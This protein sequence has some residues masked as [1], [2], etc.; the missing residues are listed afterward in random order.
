MSSDHII[1][2]KLYHMD[3]EYPADLWSRISEQLPPEKKGNRPVFLLLLIGVLLLAMYGVSS[4]NLSGSSTD[5][6]SSTLSEV[7]PDQNISPKEDG[8][9]LLP[10]PI[11]KKENTDMDTEVVYSDE[12]SNGSFAE[13]KKDPASVKFR[14]TPIVN[15]SSVRNTT[16]NATPSSSAT[17]TIPTE[18]HFVT[19][20]I[21]FESTSTSTPIVKRQS[22]NVRKISK[23]NALLDTDRAYFFETLED[24][25]CPS[26]YED[27]LGLYADIY[28]NHEYGLRSLS[29]KS[30]EFTDY[31]DDRNRTESALYSFSAGARLSFIMPSGLG[32]KTGFNY[33]QINE[34][35]SFIDPDATMIR[36][37]ITI[38][39]ILVDGMQTV[40]SDTSRVE[41][42]GTNEIT[43]FNRLK[44]FDIPLLASYSI[45]LNGRWYAEV[46][47]GALF[48]VTFSKKGRILDSSGDPMWFGNGP[49]QERVD[50]YS[51]TAG[52]SLYLGAGFHYV[53]N[54]TFDIILEPNMTY[55][56]KTLTLDSYSLDQRY[57]RIGLITGLRYKF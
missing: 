26:F 32:L 27:K 7:I 28:W 50:V 21:N 35:F 52:V 1:R 46:N 16:Y 10:I 19:D 55:N 24:P 54:D 42:P 13:A 25:E 36:T 17:E 18:D 14:D 31:V 5:L 37:V 53:W 22:I 23:L 40:V 38:D 48:N 6:G 34:K 41:I 30:S 15:L 12:V 8:N 4:L 33:G 3:A 57:T 43:T 2:E 51:A 39:T 47:A 29:S 20:E 44:T 49:T 9:I 11:E 45:N 56:L